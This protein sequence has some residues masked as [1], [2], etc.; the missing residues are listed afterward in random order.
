LDIK[1]QYYLTVA[2]I[3]FPIDSPERAV[4]AILAKVSPRTRLALIDHVTSP[5]A[6]IFPI[7]EIVRSLEEKRIE[8]LVDGAQSLGMLPL[9]LDAI[10]ASYYTGN[11]HKWLC[12]PNRVLVW[13]VFWGMGSSPPAQPSFNLKSQRL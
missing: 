7:V 6:L 1:P 2:E 5:T 4:S 8:V 13:N 11:C 10:G 3:P 12:A 9:N